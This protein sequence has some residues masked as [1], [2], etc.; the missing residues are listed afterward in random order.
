MSADDKL[1]TFVV[2]VTQSCDYEIT[3]VATSATEAEAE[4]LRGVEQH[5]IAAMGFLTDSSHSVGCGGRGMSAA[6]KMA[7]MVSAGETLRDAAGN[8]Y[9]VRGFVGHGA[10]AKIKLMRNRDEAEREVSA[11][12]AWAM[13]ET[14]NLWTRNEQVG[15]R[16]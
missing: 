4:A 1:Q 7:E 14:G 5:G 11:D 12:V 9:L 15:Q 16:P 6:D 8:S 13:W 2:R 10:G 3:V